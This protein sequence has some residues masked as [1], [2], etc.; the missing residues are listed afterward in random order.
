MGNYNEPALDDLVRVCD[1]AAQYDLKVI[2]NFYTMMSNDSWTMPE[3]LSPRKFEAVFLNLTYRQAWIDF[4]N[5]TVSR[6]NNS[7]SIWSWNMMNEPWRREWACDVSIDAFIGLWTDMKAV[8]KAYSDRPVSVRFTAQNIEDPNHFNGD[9][10]IFSLFDYLSVN[11]YERYCPSEN[12]TRVVT[13]AQKNNCKVIITEF[14]SNS[15]TD[16]DQASD[17]QR[18]LGLFRNLGLTDCIAWMWR[19]DEVHPSPDPPGQNFNLAKNVDGTPRPAF[20]LLTN[21]PEP[22]PTP[23]P[24]TPPSSTQ[25]LSPSLDPT[26]ERYVIV[27]TIFSLTGCLVVLLFKKR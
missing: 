11:Y 21:P 19:A 24:E 26:L 6:L 12:L 10:R 22:T 25:E 9:S 3:W 17:Y 15:T 2:I 16:A 8:F 18:I 20:Y 1:F 14:G 7:E 13:K 23:T 4:L 5:H 27:I